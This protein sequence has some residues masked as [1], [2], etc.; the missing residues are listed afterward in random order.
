MPPDGVVKFKPL[1][2]LRLFYG[3]ADDLTLLKRHGATGNQGVSGFHHLRPIGPPLY[4]MACVGQDATTCRDAAA[5][6][7]ADTLVA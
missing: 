2:L 4:P 7:G 3:Y 5:P 1:L 6:S